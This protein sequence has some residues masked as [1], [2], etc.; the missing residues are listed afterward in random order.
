ME[1]TYILLALLSGILGLLLLNTAYFFI[2]KH[3]I[4]KAL[5]DP[6]KK[7]MKLMPPYIFFIVLIIMITAISAVSLLHVLPSFDNISTVDEIE[8]DIRSSQKL[9]SEWTIDVATSDKLAAVIAYDRQK[10]EHSFAIYKNNSHT[11][12]NY[13]FRYGGKSTSIER[14]VR[15]FKF[16]GAVAFVS[17]NAL[18]IAAI[19]CSDGERYEI[20]PS[21]PFVLIIPDGSFQIYDSSGDIIDITQAQWYEQTRLP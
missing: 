13:V 9:S 5:R 17:M 21:M 7:R 4:N 20:D 10:E 8:K 18:H 16:E 14:G 1:L 19:E 12:V 11:N 15:V 3:H 2:Y 6:Q